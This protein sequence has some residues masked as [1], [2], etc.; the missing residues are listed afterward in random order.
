MS[1]FPTQAMKRAAESVLKE[2]FGSGL[3]MWER[4]SGA[5]DVIA[6]F[7]EILSRV[8]DPSGLRFCINGR[9]YGFSG[10]PAEDDP[11]VEKPKFT[12]AAEVQ[13]PPD[14]DRRN[15]LIVRRF[16][17]LYGDPP[18]AGTVNGVPV[19][20]LKDYKG[21]PVAVEIDEKG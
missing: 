7:A 20:I 16:W 15:D 13:K 6:Q 12:M 19:V 17:G 21:S 18:I 5:A 11:E 9:W 3:D 8:S 4:V 14:L 1:K 10:T 2:H